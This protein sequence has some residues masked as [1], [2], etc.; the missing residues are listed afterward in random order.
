MSQGARIISF[1]GARAARGLPPVEKR[2]AIQAPRKWRVGDECL[3]PRLDGQGYAPAVITVID[4]TIY[5]G[6]AIVCP[7][8]GYGAALNSQPFDALRPRPGRDQRNTRTR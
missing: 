7:L 5:G 4:R 2:A 1:A 6:R 3:V 8:R